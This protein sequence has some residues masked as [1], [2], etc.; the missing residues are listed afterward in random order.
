MVVLCSTLLPRRRMDAHLFFLREMLP[1]LTLLRAHRG[2]RSY[3]Y[4]HSVMR[5]ANTGICETLAVHA[6]LPC[7]L[8]HR[9]C[10]HL[11]L[12]MVADG[13]QLQRR[14]ICESG[15]L[16]SSEVHTQVW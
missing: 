9:S 2:Y 3:R 11:T 16:R 14:L 6:A 1:V 10:T 4:D 7:P 8:A 5:G 12:E 15:R 13:S